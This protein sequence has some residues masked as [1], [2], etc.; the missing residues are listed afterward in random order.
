M[1]MHALGTHQTREKDIQKWIWI[2]LAMGTKMAPSNYANLQSGAGYFE[3]NTL[4]NTSFQ[5]HTWV[6]Y[7]DDI[8]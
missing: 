1:L 4:E 5:P 3:A 6:R 7:I 8:L 2:G